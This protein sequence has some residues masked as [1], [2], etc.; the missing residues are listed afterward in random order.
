[1]RGDLGP[2]AD[3]LPVKLIIVMQITIVASSAIIKKLCQV[4][5]KQT[6]R[7]AVDVA[8]IQ[9]CQI[10]VTILVEREIFLVTIFVFI[11][12][13]EA[14]TATILALKCA[15]FNAVLIGA[16][17]RCA[18]FLEVIANEVRVECVAFEGFPRSYVYIFQAHLVFGEDLFLR[19]SR[20]DNCGFCYFFHLLII[21]SK[22]NF[23]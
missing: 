23:K 20:C 11:K 21:V 4:A 7:E 15:F 8:R 12:G 9:L 14:I 2:H 22:I 13:I 5:V 3:G 18:V 10:Q 1:M 16:C 17:A 19:R 6:D